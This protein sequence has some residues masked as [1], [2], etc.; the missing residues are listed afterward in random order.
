MTHSKKISNDD[1]LDITNDE[2]FVA[3]VIQK[4]QRKSNIMLLIIENM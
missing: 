1:R 4:K 2:L 3:Y